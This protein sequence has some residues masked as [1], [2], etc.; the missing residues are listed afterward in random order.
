M[1]ERLQK[2]IAHSGLTSRR[3]AE[4]MIKDGRVTVDGAPAH[5]GQKIDTDTAMVEVDG[6]PLPVAPELV[7]YLLN[8]PVDVISTVEDTHDRQTV[9]DL[10]A[11]DRR[12]YPVGRLDADS[13]G[14]LILTND[15]VLTERLTHPRYEVEKVYLARVRGQ[16]TAARVR[17]LREG[18]MLD[19]GLAVPVSVKLVD[20]LNEEALL[21][22]VLK[23]G[24]KREI[25]RMCDA[26]DL[27]VIRLVRTAIGPL[28]DHALKPGESRKLT[29]EEVRNLYAATEQ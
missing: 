2:L 6:V 1:I 10:I 25:R 29:I 22:I 13:E 17:M 28:S 26:V 8:K 11:E 16:A 19:D 21:E 5:L 14:L 7:Y 3:G 12:V 4:D 27:P 24:R 9:V 18:V 20:R 23:E 15:G